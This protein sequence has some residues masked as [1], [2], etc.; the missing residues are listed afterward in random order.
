MS[1]RAGILSFGDNALGG[2][3]IGLLE[4]TLPV[5][6][7]QIQSDLIAWQHACTRTAP[8]KAESDHETGSRPPITDPRPYSGR[9]TH[10]RIHAS[11]AASRERP[12]PP[13]SASFSR[14]SLAVGVHAR[15]RIRV[16]VVGRCR[17]MRRPNG[18]PRAGGK[19]GSFT[20]FASSSSSSS[21]IT[22]DP[23]RSTY[24]A[25]PKDRTAGDCG[26]ALY[27]SHHHSVAMED[28]NGNTSSIR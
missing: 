6:W 16:P 22:S 10:L 14:G 24:E 12:A 9:S 7:V 4:A 27:G 3:F 28:Q 19:S 2:G 8:V 5:P 1:G 26:I 25:G 21:P 17:V 23:T 13:I 11:C 20:S 15:T 18:Q